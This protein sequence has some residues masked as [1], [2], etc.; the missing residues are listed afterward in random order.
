MISVYCD[1]LCELYNPGGVATYGF[2]I[3]EGEK[4]LAEGKGVIG[5]GKG[6]TNNVA[7]YTA[8]IEAMS[9]LIRHEYQRERVTLASDSMLL[10]RQL[11][12]SWRR[13]YARP[14]TRLTQSL[15]GTR[16]K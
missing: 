11:S 9:W 1:G 13:F 6:M 8:A 3:H 7:E 16:S 15:G 12:G 2:V 4:K 14:A 5:Q 10:V